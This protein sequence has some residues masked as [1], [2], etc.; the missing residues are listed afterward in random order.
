MNKLKVVNDKIVSCELDDQLQVK[1]EEKNDF[2]DVNSLK[3]LV[4]GDTDLEIEYESDHEC[5]L[6]IFV[7]VKADVHFSLW[8]FR[9][10]KRTK[11]Q[12]KYYLDRNSNTM[13]RRIHHMKGMRELDLFHLNGE[14]AK[15]DFLLKTISIK[16]EKY[17]MVVYHNAPKTTSNIVDHGIN[18]EDGELIFNV[19]GDIP[20]GKTGCFLD[21]KNRI[22]TYNLEECKISPNLFTSEEDVTANHAAYIGKFKD[23]DVFYMMSRGIEERDAIRLLMKG[24]FL[25]NL[26]LTKEKEEKLISILEDVWR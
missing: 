18:L 2:F 6:D 15:V 22:V 14:C 9:H 7:N 13:I 20:K 16:P 24:F 10:G 4:L 3:I 1:L 5:K 23:E 17:D 26:E 11:V 21:Q 25:S 12:Y 8:E 19:T